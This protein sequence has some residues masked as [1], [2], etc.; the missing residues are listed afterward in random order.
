MFKKTRVRQIIELLQKNLG[1]RE[2]SNVLGASRNSV[3]RIR[4]VSDGYNG[5]WEELLMMTDDEL[6][7][8]FYPDKFKPKNS[9]APVDYAYVHGE[10]SKV[11]VTEVL[12]WEE[13][14]EKCK[15]EGVKPCSY[16]TFARGYK[17]YTVSKNYTSHV[18]HKPG[19]TLG[20]DWSG[21][22]MSY[23]DPNK[24]KECTAYLF[25]STFPYSQYTYIEAAASMNQSDWLYCNVHM[26]EF[27]EGSPVKIVCDN[28][29]TGVITHPKHGEIILNDAYL[30]FAEHYQAAIMP[31]EVRKPKQKPSVEGSVGKIARKVIGMLRY[32]T[33]HSLEALNRG[34]MDALAKL[35]SKEFQKRNG[36]RKILFETEEK[37]MLRA[38]PLAPF[39]I[40]GWSYNHKVGTNSHIWFEKGQYSVPSDYLNQY[41]D[42]RYNNTIV[43]IHS[44]H[45]LIA[46]HERLPSG[47]KNGKGTEASH[48]PYPVYIPE[49]VESTTAKAEEIGTN[50]TTVVCR[51]YE[52]AKIKEQG[53]MDARS[54]L[55]IAS[56]YGEKTLGEACGRALKDFHMITYNT[57]IPYI[58]GISKSKKNKMKPE[59]EKEQKHGIVRGADYYRK[60]GTK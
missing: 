26:L 60:E 8:F 2:I 42:V 36:S 33:F 31:A 50:T 56:I 28:L 7:R 21:P 45:K 41:V 58:K 37:P 23:I 51:V 38:L 4:Q 19:V 57:L 29:K 47:L 39:E 18:E 3:A 1:D 27:F 53:L 32:E 20:V 54:V 16:P 25:V 40:C 46:E 30:S 34:I 9:Y 43:H 49:T 14:C 6:Y 24:N 15:K 48:L 5:E 55:D 44:S 17:R 12:L 59:N 35:N 22:T 10:L 11:G 13:Y 52:N